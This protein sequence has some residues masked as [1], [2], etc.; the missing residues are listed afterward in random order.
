MWRRVE[1]RGQFAATFMQDSQDL[2]TSRK[3]VVRVGRLFIVHSL[4]RLMFRFPRLHIKQTLEAQ[5]TS[6][7]QK[8]V[9]FMGSRRGAVQKLERR[10]TNSRMTSRAVCKKHRRDMIISI[11]WEAHGEFL[12]RLDQSA[13]EALHLP[14]GLWV[15][16]AGELMFCAYHRTEVGKGY[17]VEVATVICEEFGRWAKLGVYF[18]VKEPSSSVLICPHHGLDSWPLDE[19]FRGN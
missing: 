18:L 7:L 2:I 15:V 10:N 6:Q 12:Q 4:G 8:Q 5:A 13:V 16:G 9:F 11:S 14:I 1:L 3:L 19:I 17:V